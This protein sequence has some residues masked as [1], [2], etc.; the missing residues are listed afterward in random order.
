MKEDNVLQDLTVKESEF[1][2]RGSVLSGEGNCPGGINVRENMSAD[3]VLHLLNFNP[4]F[5]VTLIPT[6]SA[7]TKAS[8][9]EH[10]ELKCILTHSIIAALELS[11]RAPQ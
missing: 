8:G 1:H 9:L 5:C 7:V 10:C 4:I 2:S 11:Q 6:L 3:N